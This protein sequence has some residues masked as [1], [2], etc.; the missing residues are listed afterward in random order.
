MAKLSQLALLFALV[1]CHGKKSDTTPK[2]DLDA[3]I[4][5][6]DPTLCDTNGKNVVTYDLNKDN[7]PD[8]WRLY[9][10]EDD[11][12][13]LGEQKEFLALPQAVHSRPLAHS[14][15]PP[16]P[17]ALQLTPAPSLGTHWSALQ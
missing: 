16:L 12:P 10:V 11:S 6:V 4:P 15:A 3:S 2:G 17:S 9:K 13:P 8:V 5:K 1:A 7:K 14:P